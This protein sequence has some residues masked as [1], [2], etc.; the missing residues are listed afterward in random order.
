M[1]KLRFLMTFFVLLAWGSHAS[2]DN[3]VTTNEPYIVAG[4]T[5]ELVVSLECD[6]DFQIYAYDL[7]LYLP[8]GIEVEKTAGGEYVFEKKPRNANHNSFVDITGDGSILFGLNHPTIPLTGYQGEV[9]GITLKASPTLEPGTYTG[10]IKRVDYADNSDPV[11]ARY[12]ADMSFSIVVGDRVILDETSTTAPAAADG[13]N[14]LVKRTIAANEWGTICLPFAMSNEQVTAAFGSDVQLCDFTGCDV[15]ENGD[16]DVT[17]IKVNFSPV[18]V[19]EA[20]HPYII[21]VSGAVTEFT[22]DNVDIDPADEPSVDC[23]EYKT[24]KGT[25]TDPYRYYYNSIVG[26]YVAQTEVPDLCLFLSGGQFWYSKGN[27]KMKAFRAY[28]DFYEILTS[29]ENGSAGAKIGL[30]INDGETT[31]IVNC[32]LSTVNS[33][34]GVY[35]LQGRKVSTDSDLSKLKS[36]V[37]IINGKKVVKK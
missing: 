16:G 1:K 34:E 17:A 4:G 12:P 33:K 15:T 25:K 18:S 26:T 13:V 9:L 23:D 22:A 21:K 3:V 19:I 24:G 32:Q 36:G 10:Y 35:D 6:E 5:S 31:E 37:Y 14:V 8:E 7:F 2:A 20:N 28:F 29:V 30:V 11:R 27:T